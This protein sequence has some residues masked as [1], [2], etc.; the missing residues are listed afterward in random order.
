MAIQTARRIPILT[1]IV[2][3]IENRK[4]GGAEILVFRAADFRL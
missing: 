2:R 3:R 1:T 4:I